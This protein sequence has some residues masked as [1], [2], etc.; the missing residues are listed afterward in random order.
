MDL[1]TLLLVIGLVFI[2]GLLFAPLGM[3]GGL[4]FVPILHYVADWEIDGV[5]LLVSLALTTVVSFGSG[6]AHQKQ[7]YWST[8]ARNS[9]LKGAIPGVLVGVLLVILLEDKLDFTFKVASALMILWAIQKTWAKLNSD[10]EISEVKVEQEE[11]EQVPVAIG[12]VIGGVLCS[13]LGIG[14]GTIYVPVLRQYTNLKTRTAIGTSLGIMMAVVPIALI[15]HFVAL[16]NQQVSFL[17]EE[18]ALMLCLLAIVAT[19]LGAKIGANIGLKYIPTKVVMG[20]FL[21]LLV[22]ILIRYGIDMGA[23]INLF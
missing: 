11:I 13:V 16:S 3:G 9:T 15:T 10:A 5:L 8:D 17:F 4:L 21:G 7:G 22:L 6:L 23:I 1:M 18:G 12:G 20:I 19:F 14:S 2:T